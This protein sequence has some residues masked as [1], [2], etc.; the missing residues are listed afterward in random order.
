MGGAKR[1]AI[2]SA[3][4]MTARLIGMTTLIGTALIGATALTPAAAGAQDLADY[5]YENLTFRGIGFDV[6]RIWPSNL[7]P[8]TTFRLR[9]D[10]GYLGPGVRIMP[11]IAY[12][13]SS[14]EESE[15]AAFESQLEARGA[16]GVEL[17]EIDLSDLTLQL[18]AHFVWTTP[19]ELLVYVG[20]GAGLHLLNGQGSSIDDTFIEDLFDS[21]MPGV[22]ALAGLEY[23]L[24]DRL[25]IYGEGHFSIVSDILNPGVTVGAALMFPAP[26]RGED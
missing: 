9:M 4:V 11:S 16:T 17:G 24:V 22:T 13:K 12:W 2:M 6:G 5:D 18:D 15:I 25:R 3:R 14:V 7:D 23:P 19:I 21:I 8:A 10:L 26:P 1:F 20:A